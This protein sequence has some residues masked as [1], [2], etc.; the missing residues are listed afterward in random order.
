MAWELSELYILFNR[1]NHIVKVK[2]IPVYLN[3]TQ[4]SFNT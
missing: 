2:V 4:T 3:D 1:Q